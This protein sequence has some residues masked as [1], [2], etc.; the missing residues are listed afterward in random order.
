MHLNAA[1]WGVT[2]LPMIFLSGQALIAATGQ[3]FLH[4]GQRAVQ[5][6][7][8]DWRSSRYRSYGLAVLLITTV[9]LV[10]YY[11]NNPLPKLYPDS[12]EYV[13]VTR[14]MMTQG[15]FVDALRTPVYP[16][17]IAFIYL[18]A[19]TGNMIA[20]SVAQ[21]VLF[22]FATLEL[23][24]LTILLFRRAWMGLIVG[25]LLGTNTYIISI[26]KPILSEGMGLWLVVSLAL[27]VVLFLQRWQL[28]YL[29]LL[30][31]CT[32]LLFMTRPEWVY[33][34]VP[35]FAYL[36]F[37]AWRRG[38][39]RRLLPQSLAALALVYAVLGL[40]VYVNGVQNGFFGLTDNQN[41]NLLGKILQYNMQLEA[42]PQYTQVAAIVN[43][44][45]ERGDTNPI[46]LAFGSYPALGANHW[47]LAGAY[48]DAI[49]EHHPIEFL[50]KTIPIFF[51]SS[52]DLYAYSLINANG[53][54]GA[55]LDW[56]QDLSAH[57]YEIYVLF[58]LFALFWIILL[59]MRRTA[60]LPVVEGMGAVILLALYG[61]ILTSLGG[62]IEY[63]RLHV[64]FD[65]MMLLGIC[66]PLL[67]SLAFFKPVMAG[68]WQ[69]KTAW[70]LA[71][72]LVVGAVAVSVAQSLLAGG[73]REA[74][75][76]ETWAIYRLVVY[77]PLLALVGLVVL[78]LLIWRVYRSQHPSSQPGQAMQQSAEQAEER[79]EP[80]G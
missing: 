24:L 1:E 27:L 66:G 63:T 55:P 53:Q 23:Y 22:L 36:W 43:F 57:S 16:M 56:L 65:A 41:G 20:V 4:I 72:A 31:L 25:L 35:L 44:Y 61:L 6:A 73:L 80:A 58:P 5:I 70:L 52:R 21:A 29:W 12:A 54:F 67:A 47:A 79:D 30:S 15:Q 60:R 76:P 39:L 40:Y 74:L 42:P 19:G 33:L 45:R 26:V 3:R 49:V 59:F 38:K 78:G 32:L 46:A 69:W 68:R 34:P 9:I 62:F 64:P 14:N 50:L 10:A 18:L 17:F 71:G 77:H 51:T 28:R 2:L 13:Q 48:S 8:D 37:I 75:H 7:R 11:L